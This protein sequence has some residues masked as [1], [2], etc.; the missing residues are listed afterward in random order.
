[1]KMKFKIGFLAVLVGV[2]IFAFAAVQYT[3]SLTALRAQ[4]LDAAA[5]ARY[6]ANYAAPVNPPAQVIPAYMMQVPTYATPTTFP[7]SVPSVQSSAAVND[8]VVGNISA[9]EGSFEKVVAKEGKFGLA[10]VTVSGDTAGNNFI[11]ATGP[12]P[13]STNLGNVLKIMLGTTVANAV[14]VFRILANGNIRMIGNLGILVANPQSSIHIANSDALPASIRFASQGSG[15]TA[16]DGAVIDFNSFNRLNNELNFKNYE[17]GGINFLTYKG[18]G[19]EL[20]N[21]VSIKNYGAVGIGTTNPERILDIGDGVNS[22]L[23]PDVRVRSTA[24]AIEM[25]HD[26]NGAYIASLRKQGGEDRASKLRLMTT[27]SSTG[28]TSAGLAISSDGKVGIG[29]NLDQPTHALQVKGGINTDQFCLPDGS[30]NAGS[31]C[32]KYAC[33][34]ANGQWTLSQTACGAVAIPFNGCE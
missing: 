6:Y 12:V 3:P 10:S 15:V 34:A 16:T 1:M 32:F 33:P 17:T 7:V 25:G 22:Q 4:A 14:D 13:T 26:P 24:G 29:I 11:K 31:V 28:V 27:N 23:Y 19:S 18:T 9:K 20:T 8:V 5:M 2:P 30:K 21:A